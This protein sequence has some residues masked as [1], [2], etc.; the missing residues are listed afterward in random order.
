MVHYENII[1]CS[2]ETSTPGT[3]K[4]NGAPPAYP[5]TPIPPFHSTPGT[6]T[7]TGEPSSSSK[8]RKPKRTNEEKLEHMLGVLSEL[9]WTLSEFLYML[10]RI[11]DDQGQKVIRSRKHAGMVSRF[12]GGTTKYTAGEVIKA[13]LGDPCSKNW[14]ARSRYYSSHLRKCN[15]PY[16]VY[17]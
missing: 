9:T 10:F 7:P 2:S 15:R 5:A 17:C 13:W 14:S 6:S 12:L 1:F 11:E 8:Q 3:P 4:L 16:F